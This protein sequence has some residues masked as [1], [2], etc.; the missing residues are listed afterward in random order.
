ME[1]NKKRI[2][3]FAPHPDDEIIGCGGT[4][5][6]ESLNGAKIFICYLTTGEVLEDH[7][8]YKEKIIRRKKE[9][10]KVCREG[11]FELLYWGNIPSRQLYKKYW[12]VQ[13]DIIKIFRYIKPHMIFMPHKGE[14]D[15]EHIITY[16]L[17]KE[18]YW[19]SMYPNLGKRNNQ[20]AEIYL[21]EI[22]TPL[23]K[24]HWINNISGEILKKIELLN[25]YES[26]IC[27]NRYDLAIK[28]LNAY[29]GLF[30]GGEKYGEAFYR[31]SD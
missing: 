20:I 7:I 19:L 11:D 31:E 22:W 29:R 8:E 2:L 1:L 23:I 13:K 6:K 5:I 27:Y 21:Y 15:S 12:D 30:L 16:N 3:V 17:V 14:N 25:M 4:L 26:Q 18:A 10:E 28:G 24:T 9:A